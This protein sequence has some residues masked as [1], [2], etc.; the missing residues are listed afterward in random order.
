MEELLHKIWSTASFLQYNCFKMPHLASVAKYFSN[1]A[2]A[3]TVFI[4]IAKLLCGIKNILLSNTYD[5]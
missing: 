1:L 2:L 3:V 4:F 5:G